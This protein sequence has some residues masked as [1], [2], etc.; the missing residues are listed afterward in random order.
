MLPN[1]SGGDARFDA[2]THCS[3]CLCGLERGVKFHLQRAEDPLENAEF[4]FLMAMD[5]ADERAQE[6]QIAFEEFVVALRVAAQSR[7]QVGVFSLLRLGRERLFLPVK[8]ALDH[9]G[10]AAFPWS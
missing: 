7:A 5:F 3:T 10:P 2:G 8:S 9:R 6:R 4:V 1:T